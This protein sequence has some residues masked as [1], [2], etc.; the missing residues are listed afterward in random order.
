VDPYKWR[1]SSFSNSQGACAELRLN[2]DTG[3]VEIRN[4]NE[5]GAVP[6]DMLGPAAFT[7][8]EAEAFIK[9]VKAG[10]FDHLVS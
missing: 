5:S 3:L 9:G 8:P 10:E 7:G 6:A 1:K 4:S 2:P